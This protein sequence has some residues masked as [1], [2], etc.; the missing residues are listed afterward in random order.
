L[1]KAKPFID[2]G[3]EEAAD[4]RKRR[5][6]RKKNTHKIG[7]LP[8]I[9][10]PKRSRRVHLIIGDAHAHC[11]EGNQRFEALGRMV[12]SIKPDC[13]ID[14]GDSADMSSLLGIESGSKGPIFEGFSY[15]KDIDAYQDAK[16]RYHHYLKGVSKYPRHIKLTGN[17]EDRIT[18]LL[19]IE[20]RFIGVLGM[21]DLGD[22]DF[23]TNGWELYPFLEPILV[24]NVAYSHYFKSPGSNRPISG[25]VPTRSVLMK[26]PGSFTRVFGHTHSFGFFEDA[27]GAPG[28]HFKKISSINAGCFFSQKMSGMRWS[29]TDKNRWRSG[30]LVIEVESNGQLRSWR[31]VD[32]WD[33]L[34]EWGT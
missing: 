20:P 2:K 25:V 24:D 10:I 26:Y 29:G 19:A 14:I 6:S 33:V 5:E 28:D 34:K 16:E 18:R 8:K 27:D 9:H 17:H 3:R 13:V 15:W 21:E 31:W 7:P 32:Y 11:E 22:D 4:F 1:G 12:K 30:I 23:G